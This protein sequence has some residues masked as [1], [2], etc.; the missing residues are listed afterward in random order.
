MGHL[1]DLMLVGSMV[2]N[3]AIVRQTNASHSI[4]GTEDWS[5]ALAPRNGRVS[6][7]AI[8]FS[9]V[10]LG[11]SQ[12][13]NP[14]EEGEVFVWGAMVEFLMPARQPRTR[15]SFCKCL[16]QLGRV[17]EKKATSDLVG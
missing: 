9:V 15:L 7:T 14:S 17:A 5:L 6:H 12:P 2:G 11:W 10:I 1:L 8:N 4:E 16:W 13:L 3:F